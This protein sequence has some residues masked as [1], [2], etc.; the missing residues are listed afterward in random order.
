MKRLK[1]AYLII[2][3]I[4]LLFVNADARSVTPLTES[5]FHSSYHSSRLINE[6]FKHKVLTDSMLIYLS[7]FNPIDSKIALIN[8]LG[9]VNGQQDNPNLFLHYLIL[10]YN[11]LDTQKLYSIIT[12]DELLCYSYILA[13]S[14]YH[15]TNQATKLAKEA[16][17]RN[18]KSF[19]YQFIYVLLKAQEIC[20][21]GNLNCKI[22]KDFIRIKENTSLKKDMHYQA[23][24]EIYKFFELFKEDCY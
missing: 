24:D 7:D 22:Y 3:L 19:T 16:L 5:S 11:Q 10:K 9:W 18:K 12:S 2:I 1:V 21:I 23:L 8:A 15:Y 6:A 13:M 4:L 17:R 14:N 20:W